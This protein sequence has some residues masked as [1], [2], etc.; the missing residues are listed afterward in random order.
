MNKE[1]LWSLGFLNGI[2]DVFKAE[3]S[4]NIGGMFHIME[5]W[6]LIFLSLLVLILSCWLSIAVGA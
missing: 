1:L 6:L 4:Q 3:V 5:I 2:Y